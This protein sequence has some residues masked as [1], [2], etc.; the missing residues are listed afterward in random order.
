MAEPQWTL[1]REVSTRDSRRRSRHQHPPLIKFSAE[2]AYGPS[3][4]ETGVHRLVR[5]LPLAT[6]AA[7][8]H[9]SVSSRSLA[10]ISPEMHDRIEY[11]HPSRSEFAAWTALPL[12]SAKARHKN[13]QQGWRTAVRADLH[14]THFQPYLV[15]VRACQAQ[16]RS[17][18]NREMAI[19]DASA[20]AV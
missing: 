5:I 2:N 8:R 16:R 14:P 19:E 11:Q 3:R 7:R 17:G 12:W 18:K 6:Q 1:P 20:R 4:R 15:T 10:L 13:G 9:T